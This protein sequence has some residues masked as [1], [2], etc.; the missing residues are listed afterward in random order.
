MWGM[1][2]ALN[3]RGRQMQRRR[4]EMPL[5]WPCALHPS[6]WSTALKQ[7]SWRA[8]PSVTAW[9]PVTWGPSLKIWQTNTWDPLNLLEIRAAQLWEQKPQTSPLCWESTLPWIQTLA[10]LPLCPLVHL[11]RILRVKTQLPRPD[12]RVSFP[13]QCYS[14]DLF[15]QAP[16]PNTVACTSCKLGDM[17]GIHS[18]TI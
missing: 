17:V 12:G 4:R 7:P 10:P 3:P 16:H 5:G 2:K 11:L 15:T 13:P 1:P 6:L 9:R 18:D 8:N 14:H